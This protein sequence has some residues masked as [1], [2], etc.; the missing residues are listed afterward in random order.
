M[1][2]TTTAAIIAAI[3]AVFAPSITALINNRH[4]EK[5]KRLE[6]FETEKRK[7]YSDFAKSFNAEYN[8]SIMTDNDAT[9]DMLSATYNAMTYCPKA[10]LYVF[11]AFAEKLQS[12]ALLDG[13]ESQLQECFFACLAAIQDD[14]QTIVR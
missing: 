2:V 7:V 1:D 3:S 14:L 9:R 5:M 12:G 10:K 4:T 6:L 8:A 13:D 11:R